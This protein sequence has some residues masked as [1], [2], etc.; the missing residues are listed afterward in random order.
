ML[1]FINTTATPNIDLSEGHLIAGSER[2]CGDCKGDG[3]FLACAMRYIFE[4]GVCEERWWRYQDYSVPCPS[5]QPDVAHKKLYSFQRTEV[6]YKVTRAQ[7]E[8]RFNNVTDQTGNG[9]ITD[10]IRIY[11]AGWR[12]PVGVE[13]AVFQ[14][15]GW[16][17]DGSGDIVEPAVAENPDY[18]TIAIYG[19]DDATRRFYFKNSWGTRFGKTG[20]KPGYGTIPYRY[21][22]RFSS[23]GMVGA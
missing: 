13:L 12:N 3:N 2:M 11:L 4:K 18:H 1:E 17:L 19:Y 15:C 22:D 14:Q 16:V 21:L 23:F 10:R 7:L 9:P 20:P 5:P 8:A 6:V